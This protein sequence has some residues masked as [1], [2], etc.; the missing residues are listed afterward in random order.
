MKFMRKLQLSFLLLIVAAFT[1]NA[2]RK[3]NLYLGFNIATTLEDSFA[4]SSYLLAAE[5]N[6]LFNVSEEFKIGPGVSLVNYFRSPTDFAQLFIVPKLDVFEKI[7]VGL[8]V[9]YAIG[10]RENNRNGFFL[11]P[12][13]GYNVDDKTLLKLYYSN[14][15]NGGSSISNIGVAGIFQLW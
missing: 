10:I 4:D 13:I 7:A 12:S 5:V 9:G 15:S 14:I 3:G 11:R 1:L 2:Q 8:D 6:Y